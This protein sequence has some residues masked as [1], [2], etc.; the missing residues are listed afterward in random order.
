MCVCVSISWLITAPSIVHLGVEE[1]VSVHIHGANEPVDV[2]LSFEDQISGDTLS[3][4]E[5][6][7]LS[8]ANKYQAVVK[9]K[10][11]S[12]VITKRSLED[13]VVEV[14]DG[15][16]SLHMSMC[17]DCHTFEPGSLALRS[18]CRFGTL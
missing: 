13:F 9:L 12:A 3:S 6:I 5:H 18:E 1:T 2:D 16:P 17:S 4:T 7:T 11:C 10:V 8:A 14:C 15:V